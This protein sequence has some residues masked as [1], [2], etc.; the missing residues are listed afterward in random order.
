MSGDVTPSR[1]GSLRRLARWA[2]RTRPARFAAAQLLG[3]QYRVGR[4]GGAADRAITVMLQ[5]DMSMPPE[6]FTTVERLVEEF[7]ERVD[8]ELIGLFVE[9]G[10]KEAGASVRA[11]DLG[12][13]QVVAFEANPYT[14]RRFVESVSAA[15]VDYRHAALT[16]EP[17]PQR[18]HVRLN[19]HGGPIADGQA[20]LLIRPD[21]EPGYEEVEVDGVRLDE[22]V[23]DLP[24]R[25]AMWVDVEGASSWVLRGASSV[26]DRTDVLI[27]EVE[28]RAAWDGQEWL[29]LDV[30][31]HLWAHGLRPVARDLQSRFQF[32]VLFVRPSTA[33]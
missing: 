7:F 8:P 3:L 9:A 1:T 20:S 29:H 14:H 32:N 17:G 2:S 33:P 15:G 5:Y 10:A 16:D 18:F 11:S 21:H 27:I 12:V 31:R 4:P 26:L 22:A 30:V 23:A 6:R 28:D 25:V 19:E 24:G 13:D